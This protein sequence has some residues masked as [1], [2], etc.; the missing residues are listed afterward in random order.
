MA[1]IGSGERR[2]THTTGFPLDPA[3]MLPGA[4][5]VVLV[6]DDDGPGAMMF[7]YTA[8]NEVA[9][10]S[11]HPS[12]AEAKRQAE[13]E[14]GDSLGIWEEVPVETEDPHLFAVKYAFDR[15]KSRGEW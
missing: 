14:Y 12:I 1:L 5:V 11:W 8:H 2:E 13:E 9:G 10:D 15:L 4:D 6:S 3:K 7:R